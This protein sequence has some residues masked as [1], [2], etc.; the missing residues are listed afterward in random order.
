MKIQKWKMKQFQ[1]SEIVLNESSKNSAN[2]I[3]EEI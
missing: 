1:V 2:D 3:I